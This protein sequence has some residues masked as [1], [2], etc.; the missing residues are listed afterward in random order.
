M[1][2]E[3][4]KKE[5]RSEDQNGES[6]QCNTRIEDPRKIRHSAGYHRMLY[7]KGQNTDKVTFYSA[8]RRNFTEVLQKF[9]LWLTAPKGVTSVNQTSATD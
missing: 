2:I 5:S 7:V 9:N 3:D 4:L 1:Q 6:L 8:L